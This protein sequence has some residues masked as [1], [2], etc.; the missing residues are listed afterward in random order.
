MGDAKYSRRQLGRAESGVC[1]GAG[2]SKTLLE[3]KGPDLSL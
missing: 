1:A 2:G 3:E